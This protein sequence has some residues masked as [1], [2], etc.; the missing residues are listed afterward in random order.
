MADYIYRG[1]KIHQ[2]LFFSKDNYLDGEWWNI[3]MKIVDPNGS[4]F[5]AGYERT[6]IKADIHCKKW[7]DADLIWH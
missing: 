3:V 6:W 2:E 4:E 1:Y 5:N 7:I